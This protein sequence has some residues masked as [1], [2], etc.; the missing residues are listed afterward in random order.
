VTEVSQD[1]GYV[2]SPTNFFDTRMSSKKKNFE[3]IN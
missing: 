1:V 2:S 3:A